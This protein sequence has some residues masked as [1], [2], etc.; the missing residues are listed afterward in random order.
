MSMP[1]APPFPQFTDKSGAPLNGGYIYIGQSGMNPETSPVNIYWDPALTIPAAQPLRTMGGYIVRNG[2]P[3]AVFVSELDFSITVR[4][5]DKSTV[6]ST[7]A[8]NDSSTINASAIVFVP[9]SLGASA[10]NVQDELE[11][12]R[13]AS[14]PS[15]FRSEI[16]A[17]RHLRQ[18]STRRTSSGAGASAGVPTFASGVIT[19]IPVATGGANYVTPRVLI[20]GDGTGAEATATVA[21]GAVTAITMTGRVASVGFT[22]GAGYTNGTYTLESTGSNPCSVSVVVAGGAISQVT[23]LKGGSGFTVAPTFTLTALGAGAGGAVTPTLSVIGG[24]G[25]TQASVY[26]VDGPVVVLVGDSISTENPTPTIETQTMWTLLTKEI[27]KQN[28]NKTIAFFNRAIGAQ[29]WTTFQQTANSNWPSWYSNQA[30][31]W[32]PYVQEL[33]PDLVIC[34]FGMNDRQNFV[35][36][37]MKAAITKLITFDTPP[38]IILCTPNVPTTLSTDP[39]ISSED[40]QEGRDFVAGFIRGYAE[41]FDYGLLDFNRQFRLVR[42]GFDPRTSYLQTVAT[43]GALPF[44]GSTECS[45]FLVSTTFSSVPANFW[46]GTKVESA[47][48]RVGANVY[49]FARVEDNAGKIKV[50]IIELNIGPQTETVQFSVTSTL[51]SPTSGDVTVQFAA[52]D[53]RVIVEVNGATVFDSPIYRPG[54]VFFPSISATGKSGVVALATGNYARFNPRLND[55]EIYGAIPTNVYGGNAINHPSSIG[56]KYIFAPVIQNTNWQ[57]SPVSYGSTPS[58]SNNVGNNE[59]NPR[60][61]YHIT[62]TKANVTL[63]P[64]GNC[65]NLLL[66]DATSAGLS[67]MTQNNGACRINMGDDG[68]PNQWQMNYSHTTDQYSEVLGGTTLMQVLAAVRV[69]NQPIRVPS[70]AK[71]SLPTG[72][73]AGGLIYVT[74][75]IGGATP[76]FYDG[77][78]WRR[79]ADRAVIA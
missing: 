36:S 78:N 14:G 43:T 56:A 74:D 73:G 18:F 11:K 44:T 58:L 31:E 62:K 51:A 30:K 45:D 63:T 29:T 67:I 75:D 27:A 9:S 1:I 54:G 25:Y 12:L 26:I 47:L 76:A 10:T 65:N 69:F 32:I 23:L 28:P 21:G 17:A 41:S 5:Y 52:I 68:S 46:I 60:A 79:V 49:V 37:Q 20:T 39:N 4:N 13:T 70:Y 53:Q 33:Q 71:A 8:S 19:A 6:Y 72:A 66:E 48:S 22:A 59:P 61:L 50:S 40:S 42:D 15:Y 57:N 16:N 38:D 34:A 2:T 64:A 3:A 35:P 7:L 55:V 24:S 77:S